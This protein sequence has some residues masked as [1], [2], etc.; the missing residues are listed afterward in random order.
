MAWSQSM[1]DRELWRRGFCPIQGLLVFKQPP[2]RIPFHT[3]ACIVEQYCGAASSPL[4]QNSHISSSPA[5]LQKPYGGV[6][7]TVRHSRV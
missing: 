2:W 3:R 6:R 7:H 4:E 1:K 5:M